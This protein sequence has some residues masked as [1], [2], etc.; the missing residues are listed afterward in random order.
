MT[1]F[2]HVANV[3]YLGSYLV[4][5]I[6]WLRALTI[7][8]G[9]TIVAYY[10]FMPS[11]VWAAIAWNVL[12]LAIN[13]WQIRVLLAERRPVVLDPDSLELYKLAFRSLKPREFVKVV[14]L[15]RWTQVA[16]GERIVAKGEDLDRIM[17]VVS[18]RVRVEPAAGAGIELRPGCFVGEMS[19]MT[20]ERP[21]ADV[22]AIE[23][24]RLVTW[25]Q[26]D[27]RALLESAVELRA[28][29]Q[30]VLGAD[31]IAKLHHA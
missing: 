17:V 27:L 4:K 11:P 16:S 19:F 31:L 18:G 25:P 12:F 24:T 29:V 10:V 21:N 13:A 6:L 15:A 9:L 2:I 8:G 7:L 14:K 22:V 28:A 23:P 20:G 26:K 30:G 3:I 5:D 1:I